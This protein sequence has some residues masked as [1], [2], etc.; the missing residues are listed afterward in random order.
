[1]TT[2]ATADSRPATTRTSLW[3]GGTTLTKSKST[4]SPT[5][6]EGQSELVYEWETLWD[7]CLPKQGGGRWDRIVPHDQALTLRH[8]RKLVRAA[9]ALYG[10]P[11]PRVSTARRGPVGP[12]QAC[13]VSPDQILFLPY[14]SDGETVLH[15]FAHYLVDGKEWIPAHGPLFAR[16][17]CDLAVAFGFGERWYLQKLGESVGVVF[18]REGLIVPRDR[19]REAGLRILEAM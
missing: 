17:V 16:Y 3:K 7:R 9:A 11:T 14:P 10:L 4:N 19:T 18:A 6:G 1:M 2:S 12:H 5:E 8:S 15:E 13:Y